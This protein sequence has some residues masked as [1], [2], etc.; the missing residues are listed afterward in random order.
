MHLVLKERKLVIFIKGMF[1]VYLPIL[2]LS[3]VE[4]KSK[5]VADTLS[6]ELESE[7]NNSSI[8]VKTIS[9]MG[10]SESKLKEAFN[11]FNFDAL[12]NS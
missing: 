4:S 11:S 2:V 6:T 7:S 12:H 8:F 5:S 3:E 9:L 10:N 1:S